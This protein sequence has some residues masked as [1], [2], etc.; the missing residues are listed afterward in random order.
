MLPAEG[1]PNNAGSLPYLDDVSP[2][3]TMDISLIPLSNMITEGYDP[4]FMS[5]EYST[6]TPVAQAS[7][8]IRNKRSP[9]SQK[10]RTQPSP[11][12]QVRNGGHDQRMLAQN[13]QVH[14]PIHSG[15]ISQAITPEL[16]LNPPK[17]RSRGRGRGKG[18]TEHDFI[19]PPK[20]GRGRAS[21]QG[22]VVQ[23]PH[24]GRDEALKEQALKRKRVEGDEPQDETADH[25]LQDMLTKD[26]L[27]KGLST[28]RRKAEGKP[29]K[30]EHHACDRCFRNKTKVSLPTILIKVSIND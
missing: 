24:Q 23:I 4:N 12:E 27:E 2:S 15:D 8:H 5:F 1:F 17:V 11:P 28:R 6:E 21:T 10:A 19:H 30:R 26:T 16:K 7:P 13:G 9:P 20:V 3:V 18:H 25:I 29:S 14:P 22:I